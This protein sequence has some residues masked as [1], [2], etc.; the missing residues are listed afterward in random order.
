MQH[1]YVVYLENMNLVRVI[2]RVIIISHIII[3]FIRKECAQLLRVMRFIKGSIISEAI[4]SV[5]SN[6]FF[7]GAEGDS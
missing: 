6:F 1:N 7:G 2:I 3:T 5:P 4:I